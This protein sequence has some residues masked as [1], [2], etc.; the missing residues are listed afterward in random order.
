[1]ENVIQPEFIFRKQTL[2]LPEHNI[3]IKDIIPP[4]AEALHNNSNTPNDTIISTTNNHHKE[5]ENIKYK[6]EKNNYSIDIGKNINILTKSLNSQQKGDYV[7]SQGSHLLSNVNNKKF[8]LNETDNKNIEK[9]GILKIYE[10]ILTLSLS[11]IYSII[12]V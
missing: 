7:R 10:I 9:T 12:L 4:L 11:N 2:K 1:M 8:F 6:K 3:Y 5:V